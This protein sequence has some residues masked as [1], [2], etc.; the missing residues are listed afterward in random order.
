MPRS[1]MARIASGWT[2]VFSVPGA[3]GLVP[4][5]PAHGGSPRPSGYGPSCACRGTGRA[6]WASS[7]SAGSVQEPLDDDAVA[8]LAV[9]LAVAPIDADHPE[10]A[11]LVQRAGWPYSPGRCGT[12]SSRS[13]APRRSGTACPARRGPPRCL[14]PRARRRPSVPRRPRTPDDCGRL[15]APAHATTCPSRSTTTVGKRVTLVGEQHRDLARRTRLRL[16]RGDA[17]GDPLVVD[18][19][20]G[21][22]SAGVAI[23]VVSVEVAIVVRRSLLSID[24][25]ATAATAFGG[26]GMQPSEERRWPP[27]RRAAG[28]R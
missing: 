17:I 12:R 7:A 8:P 22:A 24:S 3:V 18:R 5:P 25:S 16:E 27:R 11:A 10:P 6:S 14:A 15:P 13:R 20:D 19:R 4:S 1:A 26:G 28:R 21:G 9:E 23:R 2:D